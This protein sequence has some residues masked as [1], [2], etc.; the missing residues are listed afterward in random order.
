VAG[1]VD[2]VDRLAVPFARDSR[3]LD[4]DAALALLHHEVGRRVAVVDVAVLVDL[5]GVE[6]D[7]LGRGGLAGVDMR[8][9]AD[10][11]DVG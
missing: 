9:D 7:A 5:L 2:D 8:D 11:A 3:R 4:R 10:V 6:E 1:G